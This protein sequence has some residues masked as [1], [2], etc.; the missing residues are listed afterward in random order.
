MHICRTTKMQLQHQQNI[1]FFILIH[2]KY[3]QTSIF[4]VIQIKKALQVDCNFKKIWF[5]I[6]W[7]NFLGTIYPHSQMAYRKSI[8]Y[9]KQVE[10]HC[11]IFFG[12]ILIKKKIK[13]KIY[14]K[15]K[16]WTIELNIHNTRGR[17]CSIKHEG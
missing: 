17:K 11:S 16:L 1:V 2:Q 15:K 5:M 4:F 10:K 3:T 6:L 8:G 9:H 12:Y 13:Y 14:I 7:I